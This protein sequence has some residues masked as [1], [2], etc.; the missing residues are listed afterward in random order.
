M[1]CLQSLQS[2]IATIFSLVFSH[3]HHLASSRAETNLLANS[4]KEKKME[5]KLH[6]AI[7]TA[8]YRSTTLHSI[9]ATPPRPSADPRTAQRR[10]SCV[11]QCNAC[12]A[13]NS[14]VLCC[15]AWFDCLTSVHDPIS[16]IAALQDGACD[17]YLSAL[18]MRKTYD[19]YAGLCVGVLAVH[20]KHAKAMYSCRCCETL[21][22]HMG[23]KLCTLTTKHRF[24]AQ[25]WLS[26]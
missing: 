24:S 3:Q 1:T 15:D 7:R 26:C 5:E 2:N 13:E 8:P 22:G 25:P 20:A 18:C 4:I 17:A 11:R 23:P 21:S 19:C 10:Q 12:C 9:N 16:C 14:Y 6:P